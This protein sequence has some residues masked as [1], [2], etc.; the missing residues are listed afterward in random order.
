MYHCKVNECQF[1]KSNLVNLRTCPLH[2]QPI[3]S[4]KKL[5]MSKRNYNSRFKICFAIVIVS[6]YVHLGNEKDTKT[7]LLIANC[8]FPWS[9]AK[10]IQFFESKNL[11]YTTYNYLD[12]NLNQYVYNMEF[13][14][15]T[16]L[17]L[18]IL[19]FWLLGYLN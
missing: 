6:E 4:T 14:P 8:L 2:W 17:I 3:S 12:L 13:R 1:T 18:T 5:K 15:L 7:V 11:N 19:D 10:E 16:C 9:R